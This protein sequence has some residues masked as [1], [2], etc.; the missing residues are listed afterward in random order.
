MENAT[1]QNCSIYQNKDFII[2]AI[3]NQ[4]LSLVSAIACLCAIIVIIIFKKWQCFTQRLIL[5]L[6]ISTFLI[7][8]VRAMVRVDY[9]SG[10]FTP[11]NKG[12]CVFIGYMQQNTVWMSFNS[13]LAITTYLFLGV[14]CNRHTEKYEGVYIFFIFVIPLTFNWIPFIGN[15]F[16][17]AGAWC[18]IKHIDIETCE[19]T[20]YGVVLQ[21][22]L[23]YIPLLLLV[24]ILSLAYLMILCKIQRN[25]KRWKGS[26]NSRLDD[27][28]TSKGVR[29]EI[30]SMF[31]YPVIYLFLIIPAVINRIH[32]WVQPT[33]PSLVLWHFSGVSLPLTGLFI[34][35]I[36]TFNADTRRRLRWSHMRSAFLNYRSNKIVKEYGVEQTG[37]LETSYAR[38]S[39]TSSSVVE[40]Q[41]NTL[42]PE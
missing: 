9:H 26:A 35:L 18:W 41:V 22:V 6:M 40:L 2:V 16:G 27:P 23:F 20:L 28:A 7:S 8:L 15:T 3:V 19:V 31:I 12:F 5:Y 33:K 4:S 21:F 11:A 39:D 30:T 38:I 13:V 36:F 14:M 37:D 10:S 24:P 42:P 25:K 32:G 34:A 17:R 29:T 1:L